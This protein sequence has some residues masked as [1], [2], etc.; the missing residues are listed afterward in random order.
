MQFALLVHV[1]LEP[2]CVAELCSDFHLPLIMKIHIQEHGCLLVVT[3]L[4]ADKIF[5]V[6]CFLISEHQ[7]ESSHSRYKETVIFASPN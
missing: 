3:L 6:W 2:G 7:L 1:E 5:F 4:A